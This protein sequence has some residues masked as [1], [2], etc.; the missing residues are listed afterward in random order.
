MQT[1]YGELLNTN[2]V[3]DNTTSILYKECQFTYDYK[4]LALRFNVNIEV[5]NSF[6]VT[7]AEGVD[8]VAALIKFIN[9]Q[10]LTNHTQYCPL[11]NT[12]TLN[13]TVEDT[14]CMNLTCQ[15]R[16][17]IIDVLYRLAPVDGDLT[18]L[19]R[20]IP[21]L[22][23]MDSVTA[24]MTIHQL[25]SSGNVDSV[26]TVPLSNFMNTLCKMKLTTFIELSTVKDLPMDVDDVT[27]YLND[28]ISNLY[29]SISN[30]GQ[31][32]SLKVAYGIQVINALQ[33]IVM[34]NKSL[35]ETIIQCRM[36]YL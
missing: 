15:S 13:V 27:M 22:A 19:Y 12:P 8:N 33:V 16:V 35:L 34:A 17:S 3:K 28:S 29:F 30:P 4:P 18:F 5:P 7:V 21:G 2:I 1:I 11:C 26:N 31:F 36:T 25:I 6:T 23:T 32:A 9:N 10:G 24:I 20:Y 14:L